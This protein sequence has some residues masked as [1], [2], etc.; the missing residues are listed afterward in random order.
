VHLVIA[1]GGHALKG[2][3]DRGAG[4]IG[5]AGNIGGLL[6][7]IFFFRWLDEGR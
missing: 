2:G 4:E 7:L 1:L 6:P 5:N 3:V